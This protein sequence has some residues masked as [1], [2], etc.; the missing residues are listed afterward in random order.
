MRADASYSTRPC[1]MLFSA[2]SSRCFSGSSRC[3]DFAVLP[4]DLP[5][6][7]EQDEGDHQRGQAR[8]RRSGTWSA[9][10][11]RPAPRRRSLVAT[12][13]IGKWLKRRRRAEPVRVVDRALHA[14]RL[15]AALGQHPV[16]QRRRP[17][18]LARSSNRH[19][20]SAPASCRRDGT[21]KSRRPFPS[22]TE[23]KNF[24]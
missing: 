20:G 16:Q 24:S 11:S 12:T 9:R 1:V 21:W 8:R 10:A 23:A 6:D 3:C 15:L 7:Q 14:Q 17:E 13:T 22:A 2:V 5:D 4:G 19:A 18:F